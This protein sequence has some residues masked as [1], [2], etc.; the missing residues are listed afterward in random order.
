MTV[1]YDPTNYGNEP[2]RGPLRVGGVAV[3][4]DSVAGLPSSE[5]NLPSKLSKAVET[6]M[7]DLTLVRDIEHGCRRIKDQAQTY[8]PQA[9]N[10]AYENY[11]DRRSRSVFVNAFMQTV[12][13]LT[14][15]IFR[16]NPRV[17]EDAPEQFAL[18]WENID[19]AGTHGDV[20]A[21][22]VCQDAI[23]AGHAAILVE[24]PKTG[25]AQTARDEMGGIRPYWV[26]VK[27]DNIV[28]WRT[29]N[30]G[31]RIV[32]AQ[33]VLKECVTVPEGAFGEREEEMYRVFYR[34]GGVV[35]FRLLQVTRDRKVVELDQ[36]TYPTQD[37]IPVAEIRSAGSKSMFESTP[38]L[39][40]LAHVNIAHY[41]VS[42]DYY[43]CIH[44]T[45]VPVW[46]TI[47]LDQVVGGQ[48]EQTIGTN[49]G[50][51]LPIG[52]D[53]KWVA[54]D[55]AALES[56]RLA[57]SDLKSDMATIGLAML[58]P[59]KR[60]AETAEGK[61]IDKSA[62]DSKLGITARGLQD[63]LERAAGF[64]LRYY[65]IPEGC[66]IEVNRDFENLK[67]DAQTISALAQLV[68]QGLLTV[69]TLWSMLQEGN[70]LPGEFD[71]IVEKAELDAQSAIDAQKAMDN[72]RAM[73]EAK[74]GP[75]PAAL[76]PDALPIE[77]AQ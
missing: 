31:G 2:G 1:T 24:Y 70:V 30:V 61:R 36:G 12:Y 71:A 13:G 41:Q 34:E 6:M 51:A 21:R 43:D 23:L 49:S 38:P 64:H 56:T 8:L 68:V 57:L 60:T 40:D 22:E 50:F 77:E 72:A 73:M 20:F 65:R 10:E 62:S 11:N 46:V 7:S 54:H 48:G 59:D 3:S 66:S 25:G 67:M 76:Q 29:E 32:L 18:D 35:G 39:I 42:S 33:L 53:A 58:A 15:M 74:G 63:G 9:P 26:P 37:E 28:S 17:G 14:G 47:G 5:S 44:K 69:E 19:N 16:R 75:T 55:G 27:K 4:G 52:G 45:N